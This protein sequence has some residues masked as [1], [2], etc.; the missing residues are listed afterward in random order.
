[1]YRRPLPQYLS[2][3]LITVV[4]GLSVAVFD[5]MIQSRFQVRER[6]DVLHR[7]SSVR[8]HLESGLNSRLFLTQGLVSYVSTHPDL[9]RSQFDTLA[10]GLMAGQS[11]VRSILLA[12]NTV[13]TH[14]Y[15]AA[16]DQ[17]ALGLKLLSLPGQR[18][19]VERALDTGETVVAGPVKLSPGGPAFV[20]RTP[21]HLPDGRGRPGKGR[22]W[23]LATVVIDTDILLKESG[24]A[25]GPDNWLDYALRRGDGPGGAGG[26]IYGDAAVLR[27]NP[28]VSTV[29]FPNGSWELAA[30]P[31][32]GWHPLAPGTRW[33]RAAGALLVVLGGALTWLWVRYPNRLLREVEGATTALRQA[34]EELEA[35][36]EARTA[37]LTAANRALTEREAQ[38]AEAQQIA[39]LGSFVWDIATDRLQ[40]SDEV[41][42]IFGL[43]PAVFEPTYE[44]VVARVHPD[45]RPRAQQ[46]AGEAVTRG[47]PWCLDHRILLPDGTQRVVREQGR[48]HYDDAGAPRRM[49]GTVQDITEANQIERQLQHMAYHDPLT[50]LPNRALLKDRL[51]HAMAKARRSGRT[52]A[53]LFLDL[54]HF[55]NVN[56]SLGHAAGDRLLVQVAARL[57]THMRA[58]DTL[59]RLGGDEFTVLLE[60]VGDPDLPATVAGHLLHALSEPFHVHDREIFVAG[61]IGVS[62]YPG[63]GE[64]AGSLMKHAD[65]AMYRAKELGRG[66]YQYFSR[67]LSERAHERLALETAL[68]RALERGDELHMV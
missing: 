14:V 67:E 15:P 46:T 17:Q 59:A 42:R 68:R 25:P 66:G 1:M 2:T 64:D 48:V 19:A 23:G 24:L 20:A 27:Q 32:G 30:V 39:R 12:R 57:A 10:R 8:A 44:S 51:D 29:T 13:V 11:G 62:L 4:I 35:K 16:G 41:Y 26:L 43:D 21:I 22:Y 56:D 36:V 53:L 6:A 40:W 55:K 52:M 45:D 5:W 9:S 33:L 54:D 18:A 31:R 60:E 61:S 34:R 37:E 28:V 65:A 7:V 58:E 3:L 47:T 49:V 38:L 50:G 63:D